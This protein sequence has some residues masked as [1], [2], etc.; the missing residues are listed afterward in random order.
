MPLTLNPTRARMMADEVGAKLDAQLILT[1]SGP[2]HMTAANAWRIAYL[3]Q[4]TANAW[5]NVADARIAHSNPT[6]APMALEMMDKAQKLA[7][8]WGK[9]AERWDADEDAKAQPTPY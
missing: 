8:D 3:A 4:A 9:V 7:D 5:R 2:E 6:A 1:Q